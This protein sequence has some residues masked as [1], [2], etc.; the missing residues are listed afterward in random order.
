MA[1]GGRVVNRPS[2]ERERSAETRAF[3]RRREYAGRPMAPP[4]DAARCSS[5]RLL[6]RWLLTLTALGWTASQLEL[7]ALGHALRSLPALG[8]LAAAAAW[9][10]TLGVA[11]LRW[12]LLLHAFGAS[13]PPALR[14]LYRLCWEGHFYN[15]FLPANVAGDVLRASV[16]ASA[17]ERPSGAW[18]VVLLERACGLAALL[19]LAWLTTL[20]GL[21]GDGLEAI[22]WF[23][24][25]AHG[26]LLALAML[27][28]QLS[29]FRVVRSA[30]RPQGLLG[31]LPT[32]PEPLRRPAGLFFA[33]V[34]SWGAHLLA[35]AVAWLLLA[36][37]GFWSTVGRVPLALVSAYLP[38]VAG[39]GARE[40]AFTLLF[41][42][43]GVSPE[44]AV[45]ASLGLFAG[46]LAAATLGGAVHLLAA[47]TDPN[48]S[49]P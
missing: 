5:L 39:L 28:R 44:R 18:L 49:P 48:D 25:L 26:A 31:R 42:P 16:T 37:P 3:Q 35:G 46:Q 8:L 41:E 4:S 33:W 13:R 15:T 11:A 24:L 6:A 32:P 29:R 9:S 12:R 20:R 30:T 34:V 23:A 38:T 27:P 45:A 36:T 17:F 40:A 10:V 47:R 2:L 43:L 21:E 22:G 1:P 14:H 7:A 19:G